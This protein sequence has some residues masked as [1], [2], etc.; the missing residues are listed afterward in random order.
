MRNVSARTLQRQLQQEGTNVQT[1]LNRTRE[2]LA[3]HYLTQDAL[4]ATDIAFLLGYDEP[5]SLH[6]AFQSWTGLTPHQVRVGVS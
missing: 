1:V 6:R 2:S 3:R 4:S 5:H